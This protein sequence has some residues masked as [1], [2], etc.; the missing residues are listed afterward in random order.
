M[1]TETLMKK[2][3]QNANK[4]ISEKDNTTYGGLTTELVNPHL[5]GE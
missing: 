3:T 2:I 1:L 5:A 4:H